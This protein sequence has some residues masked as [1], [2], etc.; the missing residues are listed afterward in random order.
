MLVHNH[1]GLKQ[2]NALSVN[3][4]GDEVISESKYAILADVWHVQAQGGPL[5]TA[6]FVVQNVLF[7]ALWSE[8]RDSRGQAIYNIRY[9]LKELEG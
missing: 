8:A 3:K 6:R 9:G 7:V 5:K 1:G 4:K 2:I